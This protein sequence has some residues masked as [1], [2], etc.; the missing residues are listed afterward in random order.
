MKNKILDLLL[1]T[2]DY[3]SGEYI[4]NLLGVSR[5]SIWKHINSLKKE[6]YLIDAIRNKG[7]KLIKS[8]DT[9]NIEIV[10]KLLNT[11][12]IGRNLLHYKEVTSTN[13]V[14][15]DLAQNNCEDGLVIVSETQTNGTGRFNRQWQSPL[16]GLWMSFVL[17]PNISPNEGN[18]I[19]LITVAAMVK[20]LL[21]LNIQCK[22]KWPNDI[23]INNKKVCGILTTMNADMDK[24]NYIIVGLGINININ[25]KDFTNDLNTAT[26]LLL[27]K[28]TEFNKSEILAKFLNNFEFLYNNFINNNDL[29]EVI[30]I[31]KNNSML[32]NKEAT[33]IT[34]RKEEKVTCLGIDDF[35]ELIIKDSNGN[36][37]KVISG[38]I[39]FKN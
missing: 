33:L 28:N 27:E 2:D 12:F 21:N 9:L 1:S 6:G 35:G 7:Y 32:I 10:N 4:S 14:A 24:I 23:Y 20:V 38:E 36:I 22:I 5:N 18:K 19:T 34:L 15:K 39:T 16:G 26:S 31:C 13:L 17:K 30:K 37:K 8:P 29:S 25:E 11:K 3:I